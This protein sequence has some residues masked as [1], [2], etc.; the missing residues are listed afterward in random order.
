MV[1][2]ISVREPVANALLAKGAA[3]VGKNWPNQIKA[4][5]ALP[6]V[7]GPI[8]I[9]VST[10]GKGGP[11][12]AVRAISMRYELGRLEGSTLPLG[13]VVAR[14]EVIAVVP[15]FRPVEITYEEV[16]DKLRKAHVE[17]VTEWWV[18]GWMEVFP[19]MKW[20]YV[21]ANV[22]RVVPFKYRGVMSQF[23]V[24]DNLFRPVG[25]STK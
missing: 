3:L 12:E 19:S 18:R 22:Q 20:L 17:D 5:Q 25:R 14:A 23:P 21:I 4:T 6:N 8:G 1:R 9:Q 7:L 10:Q 13:H 2:T 24:P 15:G 16:A 11:S